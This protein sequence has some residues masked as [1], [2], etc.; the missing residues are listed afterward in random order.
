MENNNCHGQCYLAKKLKQQQEK[1][2]ESFKVNFHEANS[3]YPIVYDFNRPTCDLLNEITFNL[4]Q[5]NFYELEIV[6]SIFRP[7]LA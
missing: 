7:P 1:E 4:F 6:K 2:Q 5:P 3:I